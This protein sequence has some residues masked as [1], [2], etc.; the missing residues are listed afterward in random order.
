MYHLN[1]DKDL[2][3]ASKE[4]AD[5]YKV[6]SNPSWEGVQSRLD[7]ELPVKE[8]K[9][10]RWLL[11]FLLFAGIATSGAM[12]WRSTRSNNSV[13]PKTIA[14]NQQSVANDA[15]QSLAQK[16]SAPFTLAKENKPASVYIPDA[17]TA[18]V[19]DKSR[20]NISE[21]VTSN[22]EQHFSDNN[23]IAIPK[24]KL[25]INK[26]TSKSDSKEK[27]FVSFGIKQKKSLQNNSK[28]GT[29]KTPISNNK[30]SKLPA[31]D[32]AGNIPDNQIAKT[33]S[34]AMIVEKQKPS[35]SFPSTI[36]SVSKAKTEQSLSTSADTLKNKT[37]A[38]VKK[39][40][41]M[42]KQ[43]FSI[44][45]V[46][47]TDISTIKFTYGNKPG[48]HGGIIAGYHLNNIWSVHTGAIYTQNNYKLTGSD[49]HPPKHYWTQYVKLETVEGYCRMWEIPVQLRYAFDQSGNNRWFVSAGMSSYLMKKQKYNYNY[50]NNAGV[51]YSRSW[52]TDSSSKYLF[53]ILDLSAGWEKP[54]GKHLNLQVA[55]YAK[56]PLKGVGFGNIRLSSFGINFSIQIKQPI[57]R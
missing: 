37:I 31:S 16:S 18:D 32:K 53:S 6:P 1:D 50:K 12:I 56:I 34:E 17:Q 47:G 49:Y 3:Q 29:I 11:F 22:V 40:K 33:N 23:L 8:E 4:A 10:R 2:D 13:T 35:D 51:S 44:A 46:A 48:I 45:L 42:S 9:R 27:P 24:N 30:I 38:P 5:N 28:P 52:Q 20:K 39:N 15:N 19:T 14:S 43:A 36:N 26:S 25:Q 21:V 7:K 41:T 55:P 54:I 57:R